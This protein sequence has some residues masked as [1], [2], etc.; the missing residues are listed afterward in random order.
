[1][2]RRWR[3]GLDLGSAT[4]WALAGDYTIVAS[5]TVLFPKKPDAHPG[6]RLVSFYNWLSKYWTTVDEIHYEKIIGYSGH[7]DGNLFNR[8]YA[9]LEMW[10]A[11]TRIPL[12]PYNPS[13]LKKEFTGNGRAEKDEMCRMAMRLGWPH[14]VEG[15]DRFHDEADA[16]A[17]LVVALKDLSQEAV[18]DYGYG[19]TMAA[20]QPAAEGPAG[21]CSGAETDTD[22]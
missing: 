9:V 14:G 22:V 4:G 5:G 10:T 19:N 12:R 7:T 11:Q 15:T 6:E 16:V 21:A 1:M 3:L 2:A 8:F 17:I 13:H 20:I 18:F